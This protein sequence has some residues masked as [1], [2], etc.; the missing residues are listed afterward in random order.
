L[1]VRERLLTANP[2]SAQAARDVMVSIERIARIRAQ[3]GNTESALADQVRALNIAQQ[4]WERSPSYAAG[5]TFA[6]SSWL[7]AQYA[8]AAEDNA[9]AAQL[10]FQCFSVLDLFVRQGVPLDAEMCQLH[11]QLKAI[12][13]KTP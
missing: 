4:L 10:L 8:S 6:I 5:R 9:K 7:T 2:E 11:A 1:E 3:Q 12:I 13:E